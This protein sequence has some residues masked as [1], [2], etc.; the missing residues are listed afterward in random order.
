MPRSRLIEL[1]AAVRLVL[2]T[3]TAISGL[4]W[5]G[6]PGRLIQAAVSGTIELA[7]TTAMLA[8]LRGV[9]EREKFVARLSSRGL[10]VARVFA[11]YAALVEVVAPAEI[12]PTI[13]R[14]PTDDMVLAAA[15]GAGASLI[16][17]GDSHLLD[18]GAFRGIEIVPASTAVSMI[19]ACQ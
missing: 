7:C 8:E 5:G 15:V 10:A 3:N 16:V 4:L 19:E 12:P 14:D 6:Q 9:L 17:S 11:G 13:E 18:L 2:D 1:N